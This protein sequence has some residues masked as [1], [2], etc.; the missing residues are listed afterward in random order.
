M[1]PVTC[2]YYC[3]N[4]KTLFLG[5]DKGEVMSFTWPNK[6]EHLARDHLKVQLHAS[7]IVSMIV[8]SDLKELATIGED[9]SLC[10]THLVVVRNMKRLEG[11]EL[12]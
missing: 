6:P 2:F 3:I 9:S 4:L 10:V 8:S 5:T 1:N 12:I 7:S 11:L